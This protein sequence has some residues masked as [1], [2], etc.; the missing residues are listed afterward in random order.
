MFAIAGQ[1]LI[2]RAQIRNA[3]YTDSFLANVQV[4]KPADFAAC[5]F[6]SA[7]LLE[8][9]EKGHHVMHF[10]QLCSGKSRQCRVANCHKLTLSYYVRCPRCTCEFYTSLHGDFS[11]IYFTPRSAVMYSL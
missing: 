2:F 5:V 11:V 7:L 1:D 9:T 3:S 10:Q 8:A 6:F 4:H